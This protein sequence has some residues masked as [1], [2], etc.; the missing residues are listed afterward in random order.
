MRLAETHHWR[1]VRAAAFALGGVGVLARRP[2]L[3]LAA[4]VAVALAAYAGGSTAPVPRLRIERS[5]SPT[6]PEP[7][8]RVRVRTVVENV[9]DTTLPDCRL[10]DDVPAALSVVAGSPRLGTALRPGGRATLTYT[11]RARRGRHEFGEVLALV[12]GAAG[13]TEREARFETADALACVPRLDPTAALSLRTLA[14]RQAGH[15][16]TDAGGFGVEFHAIREYRDGDPPSRIDWN[17]HARTGDLATIEFR[18]ERAGT[19]VVLVDVRRVAYVDGDGDLH[20]ADRAVTAAAGLVPALLAAGDRAGVAA[21]GPE[22]AWLAPGAGSDHR[23]RARDL[24]ATHPVFDPGAP[25]RP[26]PV[27]G[28]LRSVRS[29]LTAD[30]QIVFITPLVDDEAVRVARLLEADGHLV[31]VVRRGC[32]RRRRDHRTRRARRCRGPR[33]CARR[34]VRGRRRR[35]PRVDDR[36]RRRRGGS[37]RRHR[38]RRDRRRTRRR[39]PRRDR[40]GGPRVGLGP[41]CRRRRCP[42]RPGRR[43]APGRSGPRGGDDRGRDG[44]RGRG[45]D[46]VSTR[47]R[48]SAPARA[49]LSPARGARVD[50]CAP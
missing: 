15:I 9:G 21:L 27:D 41:H 23:A 16:R 30:T 18:R 10:V 42:A 47:R 17:R 38:R 8:D 36:R 35:H 43:N 34:Y 32:D 46:S 20:A 28:R 6:D 2:P 50:G 19:V 40:R 4:A 29:R 49:G 45:L 5:F 3:L 44:R 11:V 39:G 37:R 24:L 31:T 33:R 14:S 48:R 25:D 7:G 13:A 12:R 26:T 1:G 22:D